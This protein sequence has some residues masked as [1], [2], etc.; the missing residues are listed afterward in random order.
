V[1]AVAE[2]AAT[3]VRQV[4]RGQVF[5]LGQNVNGWVRLRMALDAHVAEPVRGVTRLEG[6]CGPSGRDDLVDLPGRQR[7]GEKRQVH[8]QVLGGDVAAHLDRLAV[9]QGDRGPG[10]AEVPQP[11]PAVDVLA[12]VEHLTARNL[13]HGGGR[14]LGHRAHRRRRRGDEVGV[15]VAGDGDRLPAGHVEARFAP[16]FWPATQVGRLPGDQV[17][18]VD[19]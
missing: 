9:G 5:D 6:L 13:A 16:P 1:R 4:P 7:R 8:V 10:R 18:R 14:E 12:E 3:A 2:L 17:G 15:A 19:V 11:H